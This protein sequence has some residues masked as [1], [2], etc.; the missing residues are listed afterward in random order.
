MHREA[1]RVKAIFDRAVEINSTAERDDFVLRE[2]ADDQTDDNH[3][4]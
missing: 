1:N 4:Q 3:P 2:C